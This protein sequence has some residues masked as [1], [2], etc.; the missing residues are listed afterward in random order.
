MEQFTVEEFQNDFDNLFERVNKGEDFKII[1][2]NGEA[3]IITRVIY[4]ASNSIE[5]WRDFWYND[6][7]LCDI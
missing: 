6:Y 7:S 2:Q 3:V 4:D 5:D 1:S